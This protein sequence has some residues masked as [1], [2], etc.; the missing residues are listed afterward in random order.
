MEK[1]FLKKL[2]I[3]SSASLAL[4][5]GTIF[6]CAGGDWDYSGEYNT[7]FTPETF[8]NMQ[9]EPLFLTESLFYSENLGNAN[10]RFDEEVSGDWTAYLNGKIDQ[11]NI[12]YFMGSVGKADAGRMY[13][14]IFQNKS[15]KEAQAWAKKMDVKDKKVKGF[16]EFLHYGQVTDQF[17]TDEDAWDYEEK[18]LKRM[19]DA[20]FIQSLEKKYKSTNDEFL[21]NRY[22][23]QVIKAYFY[24]KNRGGGVDFFE[25][26]E[27]SQPKNTLYYRALSYA[28]GITGRMGN[29][30]KSNYMYSQVFDKCP[31]LQ[32]VAVFCF[33]PKEEKDWNDAFSYAKTTDEKVALWAIQGYYTDAE[34]GIENIFNL[35]PK[36]DYLEFLL[37]RLVNQE[38]LK[39][40]KE[41]KNQTVQENKKAIRDTI[42][43]TAVSLIDRIAQSGKVQKPYLWNCA[44]GYLQTLDGNFAKADSYFSKAESEMP[45][46]DL[47]LKQLRLLKF[48]NKLSKLDQI[49]KKDEDA[50]V[51]DLNWLYFELPRKEGDESKFRYRNAIEWSKSYIASLYLS[52]KNLMMAELFV[53]QDDFYYSDSRLLEI[54]AFLNK[55]GKTP[56]EEIARD[57][58]PIKV[59]Q[60]STFQ[61]VV[62]TYKDKINDAIKLMEEAGKGSELLANPFNGNIQDCHD[63]DFVAYQKK[64]YTPLT[65]LQTM[66]VMKE[67]IGK[68]EDVYTNALLL[69]N[70][71]YNITHYGNARTFHEGDILGYGVC[72]V[73]FTEKYRSLITDCSKAKMYYEMAFKAAQNDEQRARAQYMIAKCERNLYYNEIF[74]SEDYCWSIE[75][76]GISF[77]EWSGFK[78]LKN[79]YSTTKYY[80][81]VIRECGYFRT[82]ISQNK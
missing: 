75:G 36:S 52:Q 81:D 64:K 79:N 7:N 12:N 20:P 6:A 51:A 44:A 47:A 16:F 53:R 39:V 67:S 55:T 50:L 34:R 11:D 59:T 15:S 62:S 27:N 68:N 13:D 69:G 82:Y 5:Y 63:C 43:K 76:N 23:F 61:A 1:A 48:V 42:S 32:T 25:K 74:K 57:V 41:F 40:N 38:E 35:N 30:A 71:F 18:D 54:K 72:P 56:F 37:A 19:D 49:T 77:L 14:F 17:S 70:A 73:D 22:W 66:K 45:K 10:T 31:K 26:T 65:M 46:T 58:Y 4:V 28:A 3:V 60:I 78:N 29:R 80:Q 24:S 2:A 21:K 9:Y 33:T 8:V